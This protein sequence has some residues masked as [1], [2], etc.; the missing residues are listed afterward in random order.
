MKVDARVDGSHEKET[1]QASSL[2]PSE[3]ITLLTLDFRPSASANCRE[4]EFL[5]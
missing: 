3:R 5:L 4:W 2:E 1:R